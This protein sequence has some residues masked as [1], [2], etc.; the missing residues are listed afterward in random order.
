MRTA[1]QKVSRK[2]KQ[3]AALDREAQLNAALKHPTCATVLVIL[4]QAI[5]LL[6]AKLGQDWIDQNPAL[7]ALA[8]GYGFEALRGKSGPFSYA[9]ARDLIHL[10]FAAGWKGKDY[11][12]RTIYA[13]E[14]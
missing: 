1:G 13:I 6:Q 8:V 9:E 12:D 3:Q 10:A 7:R 11:Q 5:G 2:P 4:Q 14:D